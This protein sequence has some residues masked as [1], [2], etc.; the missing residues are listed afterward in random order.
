MRKTVFYILMLMI[1]VG[2]GT[3]RHEMIFEN[4]HTALPVDSKYSVGIVQDKSGYIFPEDEE[5]ID[6]AQSMKTSLIDEL[7]KEGMYQE[8]TPKYSI[9]L[10]VKKYEPGNAFGRWLMPGA[11]STALQVS[12][13]VQETNRVVGNIETKNSID[14]GGAYSIGAWKTIFK[15]A[16][17]EIVKELKESMGLIAERKK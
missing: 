10:T 7:K 9:E 8:N 11:G 1:L 4:G 16:A 2:C 17:I 13:Q 15:D 12:S 3:R 14:A 6:I 5:S